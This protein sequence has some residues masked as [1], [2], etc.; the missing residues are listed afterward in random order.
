MFGLQIYMG[1]RQSGWKK[2]QQQNRNENKKKRKKRETNE[3]NGMKSRYAAVARQ[4]GK[5][6]IVFLKKTRPMYEYI[7]RKKRKNRAEDV[8]YYRI[9]PTAVPSRISKLFGRVCRE[10]PALHASTYK[11]FYIQL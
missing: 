8:T 11:H 3:M 10:Y 7:K 2:D 5:K 9:P 1:E 4:K 6:K